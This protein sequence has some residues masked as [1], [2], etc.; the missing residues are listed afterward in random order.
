MSAWNL[1]RETAVQAARQA[2]RVLMDWSGRITVRTKGLN[3]LVTEADHAS[4]EVLSEFLRRRFPSDGF[5]GEE[6]QQR[7][8]ASAPRRWIVDPLDGTTNFVHGLPFYCVS[9]GLEVNGRLVV[10]V[11]YDPVRQE[12]FSAASG[13]GASCNGVSIQVS[14]TATL[15]DSLICGGAPADPQFHAA[16]NAGFLRISSRARSVRRLGSAA[17]ALAYVAAGRL[18]GYWAVSLQ[19]WDSAA[20]VLIV[21]EAGGRVTN[22]DQSEFDLY[23]PDLVASNGLI[24]AALASEVDANRALP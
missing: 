9:I 6:G 11:I 23:T 20:G 5:V 8:N 12:C 4:Q 7:T 10:G 18:D 13:G 14:A 1:E 17:L 24:H 22:F 2:G 15:S 19:P 21:Q 16:A 3:D